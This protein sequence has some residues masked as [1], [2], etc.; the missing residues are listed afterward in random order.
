[1]RN[2]PTPAGAVQMGE[3]RRQRRPSSP[4]RSRGAQLQRRPRTTVQ[5]AA[6]P[7]P[8]AAKSQARPRLRRSAFPRGPTGSQFA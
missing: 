6:E 3:L 4:R 5:R 2:H 7:T 1:M 8:A